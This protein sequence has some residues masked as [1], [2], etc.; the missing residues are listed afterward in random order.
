M[1]FSFSIFW[2]AAQNVG[3][4]PV[5]GSG[6]QKC[7]SIPQRLYTIPIDVWLQWI[8]IVLGSLRAVSAVRREL[9]F[10]WAFYF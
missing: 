8:F 3:F 10:I 5:S 6:P 4:V 9:R 1:S 2:D 7:R